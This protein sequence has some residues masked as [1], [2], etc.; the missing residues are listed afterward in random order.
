MLLILLTFVRLLQ[1]FGW[2]RKISNFKIKTYSKRRWQDCFH[3][4]NDWSHNADLEDPTLATIMLDDRIKFKVFCLAYKCIEGPQ[5]T[6]YMQS[7]KTPPEHLDLEERTPVSRQN[8]YCQPSLTYQYASAVEWNVIS[9]DLRNASEK[10]SKHSYFFQHAY[11]CWYFLS[12]IYI[13]LRAR[14]YMKYNEL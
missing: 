14:I 8:E 5:I 2:I 1:V 9:Q 11:N 13:T 7:H 12:Y 3:H 10:N 4:T 6:L